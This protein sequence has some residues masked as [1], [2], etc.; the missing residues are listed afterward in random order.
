M[1]W[2]LV[3][4]GGGA[5]GAYQ[6][7]VWKYLLERSVYFD[8]I[9]G[10][11]AGALNAV[12]MGYSDFE[13][14]YNIWTTLSLSRTMK[15]DPIKALRHVRIMAGELVK[16]LALKKLQGVKIALGIMAIIKGG[17]NL[18]TVF[19]EG[20][21]SIEPLVTL[22]DNN[23]DYYNYPERPVVYITTVRNH[24]LYIFQDKCYFNFTEA[25]PLIKRKLLLATSAIPL[26]FPSTDIGNIRY[27]DG[28]IPYVGD[29]NPI[30]P[31]YKRRCEHIVAIHLKTRCKS[32]KRHY[33][34]SRII[35]VVPSKDLGSMLKFDG[36]HAERLISLGYEDSHKQLKEV[37]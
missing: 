37:F 27:S 28:G 12:L 7:G 9:S 6:I 17:G 5:K 26:L 24:P 20:L 19:E 8:Y 35:D 10:T 1:P 22:I 4:N 32:N 14:A 33:P 34:A 3:L 31:I 21:V 15:L 29:N 13:R 16:I 18:L 25:H 36:K 11:S 2:G 23:I 30:F